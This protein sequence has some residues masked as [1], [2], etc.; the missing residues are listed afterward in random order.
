MTSL[1]CNFSCPGCFVYSNAPKKK[2][3]MTPEVFDR[4]L[5]FLMPNV[6]KSTRAELSF[7]FY[8]GEPLLNKPLVEYAAGKIK[9]LKKEGAFGKRKVVLSMITNAS[10]IDEKTV[11]IFKKFDIQPSISLDGVGETHDANRVFSSG[12]GTFDAVLKGI[13][14]L[15]K[16]D[17]GYG[18][19]CTIGPDNIDR[20]PTDLDWMVKNLKLNG[21]LFFN[22]MQGVPKDS[23]GSLSYDT[24][25]KKMHIIYD[26]MN[27]LGL[28]EGRLKRYRMTT[29]HDKPPYV[30][31]CA[32]AGSGQFVFRP[33]GKIGLCHAGMMHDEDQFESPDDIGEIYRNPI[34]LKWLPRTPLLMKDCYLKC[35]Y[36]ALCAGGC[37]YR[38]EKA[39]GNMYRPHPQIC[40]KEMFLMERA[41]MEDYEAT[42]RSQTKRAA[43]GKRIKRR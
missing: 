11:E 20:L 19:S 43:P 8:G 5:D 22:I 14:L 7:I 30:F 38:V 18:I 35:P 34:R 9:T 41:I 1:D 26:K 36:F 32:A 15:E 6:L 40:E 24:F 33:D 25:K 28:S 37:P 31:Y 29:S 3:H 2:I 23:F 42:L 10:L 13:R 39:T 4:Q 12:R 27:E 21:G 16:Y 17:V